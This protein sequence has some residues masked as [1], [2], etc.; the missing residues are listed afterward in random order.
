MMSHRT[1]NHQVPGIY[2]ALWL[3]IVLYWLERKASTSPRFRS[4]GTKRQFQ[5]F[6]FYK[7]LRV[8]WFLMAR[9]TSSNSLWNS[10]WKSA[11]S[12]SS[13]IYDRTVKQETDHVL[14]GQIPGLLY[15]A[16]TSLFMFNIMDDRQNPHLLKSGC[17]EKWMLIASV[18]H[19]DNNVMAFFYLDPFQ[20][21][22]D[23]VKISWC[24]RKAVLSPVFYSSHLMLLRVCDSTRHVHDENSWC[25]TDMH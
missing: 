19:L 17:S 21:P 12:Q 14:P 4:V 11:N 1:Q 7:H 15:L 8:I 10:V 5:L 3:H 13:L 18:S 9:K 6:W 16:V 23:R 24:R 22:E 2:P 20:Q 25:Y